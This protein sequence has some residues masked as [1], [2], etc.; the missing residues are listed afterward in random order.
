MLGRR[1]NVTLTNGVINNGDGSITIPA[2]V[3]SFSASV[4]VIDD[5]LIENTETAILSIG[6]FSGIGQIFDNDSLPTQLEPSPSIVLIDANAVTEGDK[7]EAQIQFGYDVYGYG[8]GDLVKAINAASDADVEKMLMSQMDKESN[9]LD[10][11]KEYYQKFWTRLKILEKLIFKKKIQ[12]NHKKIKKLSKMVRKSSFSNIRR[13][14]FDQ[15][16]PVQPVAESWG[17]TL[18]M[19]EE[20]RQRKFLCLI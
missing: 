1:T 19:T 17:G 11:R 2:G 7:V 18:S 10:L 3:Q 8:V 4:P 5:S 13:T 15:S 16:S 14:Q 12:K 6:S 9:A 20:D